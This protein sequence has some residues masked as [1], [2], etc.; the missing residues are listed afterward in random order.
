MVA[1][2]YVGGDEF[3]DAGGVDKRNLLP[4]SVGDPIRAWCREGGEFQE[5]VSDLF[6]GEGGSGEVLW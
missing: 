4:H 6:L 2:T 5:G 1:E 3:E